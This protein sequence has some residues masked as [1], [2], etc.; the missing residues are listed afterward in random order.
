M[1]TPL[2]LSE[3]ALRQHVGAVEASIRSIV[4]ARVGLDIPNF[5]VGSVTANL[6]GQDCE[7]VSR[8]RGPGAYVAPIRD[9][10][11]ELWAWLGLQEDWV[12]EGSRTRRQ[13]SF[14]SIGLTIHFGYKNE[15]VKPQM[16]RAEWSGWAKWNASQY[17]FQGGST[18]HPHWQFDALESLTP[19]IDSAGVEADLVRLRSGGATGVG[20]FGEDSLGKASIEAAIRSRKLSRIHFPSAAAWWM[21]TPRNLHAHSP[22]SDNEIEVWARETL[23]Y[24]L[25]ELE[26][27]RH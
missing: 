13:Y 19:P 24:T 14:R 4:D 8:N 12:R 3:G 16:F 25:Q 9:M 6:N 11:N 20:E 17:G 18:S 15:A 1:P 27:V 26:R 22:T 10:G 5:G 23:C 2:T 21:K 7:W